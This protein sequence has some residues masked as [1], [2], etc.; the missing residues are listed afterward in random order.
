MRKIRPSRNRDDFA[1]IL[2]LALP[3]FGLAS[4][5]AVSDFAAT[6]ARFGV[7]VNL[8]ETQCCGLLAF[9]F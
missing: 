1:L 6:S 2:V 5:G 8:R 3:R 7:D 4:F 9:D